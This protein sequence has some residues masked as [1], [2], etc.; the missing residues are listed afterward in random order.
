MQIIQ[1][2]VSAI[3]LART[4]ASD[5]MLYHREKVL[6]GLKKDC[7]FEILV[8]ELKEAEKYYAER[9][10]PDIVSNHSF[11]HRAIADVMIKAQSHLH[12]PLW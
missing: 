5:M 2:E 9:V 11:L 4:I 8:E 3:R 10:S 7:L 6:E 1:D 12:C